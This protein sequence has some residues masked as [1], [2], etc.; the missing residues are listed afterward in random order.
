[1]EDEEARRVLRTA[2]EAE[3]VRRAIGPKRVAP[4]EV[5][6]VVSRL[7]DEGVVSEEVT[8]EFMR[9]IGEYTPERAAQIS[10][11]MQEY[12]A[13]NPEEIRRALDI[14]D[15]LERMRQADLLA[16]Q[17]VPFT[18]RTVGDIAGDVHR[19]LAES[20]IREARHEGRPNV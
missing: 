10:A 3:E 11:E 1:R 20:L 17:Q 5:N 15:D 8:P 7:T 18:D 4:P 12:A 14:R 6:P 19:S 13:D 9:P 2:L 16:N